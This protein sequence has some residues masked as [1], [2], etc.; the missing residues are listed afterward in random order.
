[1]FEHGLKGGCFS[2]E[3]PFLICGV[4]AGSFA[5]IA[6]HTQYLQKDLV[7]DSIIPLIVYILGYIEGGG[8]RD[9]VN[10]STSTSNGGLSAI[11]SAKCL[12]AP[13]EFDA[14]EGMAK[15]EGTAGKTETGFEGR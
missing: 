8:G 1:M 2:S 3:L 4:E 9:F 11:P 7:E 13:L 14:I 6:P 12:A 10:M 5:N 15:E